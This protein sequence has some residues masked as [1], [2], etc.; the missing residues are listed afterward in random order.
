MATNK[1][2]AYVLGGGKGTRLYPL[3]RDRSKPAVPFGGIY[4]VIDFALSNLVN[5]EIRRIYVLTQYEPRSLEKHISTGWV[6][7]VGTGLGEFIRML[8]PSTGFESEWYKGT[9]DA[10]TQNKRHVQEEENVNVVDIFSGDHVYLMNV[11][12]INNFHLEKEADLT[13]SAIPVRR[14][15]AAGNYGVIEVDKEWQ[16]TG[17]EEKPNEPKPMLGNKDYCL[18]SMGN[19]VFNPGT[20]IKELEKDSDKS[21]VKDRDDVKG[22]EDKFSTHDFGNDVIPAMIRDGSRI[23]AYNFAEN[24]IPG[25]LEE[26]IKRFRK[27]PYWR[28]I[29]DLDQFYCANMEIRDVNPLINLYNPGWE[30]HTRIPCSQPAKFVGSNGDSGRSIDSLVA[31]GVII[32]HSCVEESVIGYR[33]KIGEESKVKRSIILGDSEINGARI[34]DSIIDKGVFVPKGTVIGVDKEEDKKREFTLSKGGITIVPRN[35]R[36]Q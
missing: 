33:T 3:T 30:I 7:L 28:D 26:E 9:A 21:T 32:S 22:N 11:S 20:L 29:G 18:V 25:L 16:V 34:E 2:I 8:P 5:S 12:Q 1:P 15:L 6:N 4:R 13:I 36:F 27:N 14:D 31:N 23:F 35:Y 10:V 24:E 17:F 19:Y